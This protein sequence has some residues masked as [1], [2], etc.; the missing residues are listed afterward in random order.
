MYI[1]WYVVRPTTR[2]HKYCCTTTAVSSATYFRI[3]PRVRYTVTILAE[4]VMTVES[5]LIKINEHYIYVQ[6]GTE[7]T[8]V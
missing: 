5:L 3:V 7:K 6:S 8:T 1:P 4:N 2:C